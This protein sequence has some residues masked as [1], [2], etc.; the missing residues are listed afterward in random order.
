MS[1]LD[2]LNQPQREAVTHGSG[3]ILILAGAGSGKT[4]VL[5]HRVAYLI[6][7]KDIDPW[8]ILGVTFTN[9]A[10]EEMQNRIKKLIGG[11]TPELWMGTFHAL[12]VRILRRE[13]KRL[14]Y[15]PGFVIYDAGETRTLIKN[16]MKRLNLDPREIKPAAIQNRISRLKSE[17]KGPQQMGP[18]VHD[19]FQENV[20]RVYY[21]Y[22]KELKK[23]NALD[24][25]DLIMLTVRLFNAHPEVRASYQKRFKYILVDEY[26]DV[27]H[28]QYRWIYLLAG[29]GGNLTV[30]G[31]PDQGI[32]GFRGADIRN[33][34]SFEEDYPQARVIK[35][36]ENYRS[37]QKILR[38]AQGVIEASM[39]R[40]EKSLWTRKEQGNPIILREFYDGEEEASFIAS[41]IS[42]LQRKGVAPG[43][44]AIFYRT[45]AQ[46]RII[47]TALN[48]SGIAYRVVGGVRFFDRR[49]IKDLLAYLQLI[50]NPRDSM[51]LLRVINTPR[52]GIGPATVETLEEV[53]RQQGDT[54]YQVLPQVEEMELGSRQRNSLVRFYRMIEEWREKV[55]ELHPE[56]LLQDILDKTGYWDQLAAGDSIEA[57]TRME[58]IQE[59]FSV[60]SGINEEGWPA[61]ES[62]LGEVALLTDIDLLDEEEGQVTLMTLHT[63]KG[64]EFP[65]VFMVGMEEGFCPHSRSQEDPDQIEE[66]RRLCYVGMTR[67]QE[68]LYITWAQRRT[69]FGT[70]TD[71]SSSEFLQLI[72]PETCAEEPEQEPAENNK[73]NEAGKYKLG[74]K[75][76]HPQLGVGKIVGMD[77]KGNR[78][79]LQLTLAFD[80]KGIKNI[81]VDYVDLEILE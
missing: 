66:E 29:A 7:E 34:L 76:R 18:T 5:T 41:E 11:S 20:Y 80:G 77:L 73:D 26:Q 10:A 32:Y 33:I 75:V 2:G 42:D 6:Q 30:V 72:P 23:A 70:S 25:D 68:I 17:L 35:L 67:A 79:E 59:L 9:K 8:N 49:E 55:P 15:S 71:R 65:V 19:A 56:D 52:R 13:I 12:S 57:Q 39:A 1:L 16:I 21:E 3:P 64:L 31:D 28:A 58:N 22:Q 46:S 48:K 50:Y 44:I 61:L 27:N 45:N 81:L 14:G 60:M 53:A 74:Q 4:R 78:Q 37:S 51:S 54:I 24:F 40:R 36:E 43:D 62:F 38:G 69:I 47:E 63:A